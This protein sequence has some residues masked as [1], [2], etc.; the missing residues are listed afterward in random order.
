[1]RNR[2]WPQT[3]EKME[4]KNENGAPCIRRFVP[5]KFR[6]LRYDVTSLCRCIFTKVPRATT[7]GIFAIRSRVYCWGKMRYRAV[8]R[9]SPAFFL[10][11]RVEKLLAT[12][13]RPRFGRDSHTASIQL[14][15]PVTLSRPK[16]H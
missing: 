5:N 13:Q 10:P 2:C 9:N 12:R 15:T 14:N 3:P 4:W 8:L 6:A 1:L 7:T 11:E 16:S